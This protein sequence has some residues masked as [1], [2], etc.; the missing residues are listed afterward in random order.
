V[1]RLPLALLLV[2]S[3]VLTSAQ[4]PPPKPVGAVSGTRSS[5]PA[6]PV[7]EV[8][9]AKPEAPKPPA[10]LTEV[11]RL[12][13]QNLLQSIEL[14]QLKA[15]TAATE[16]TKA[17]ESLTKFLQAVTPTGWRLNDRLEFVPVDPP[18]K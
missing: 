15:Q 11:Q 9:K 18:K 2:V 12:Q 7:V 4:T 16:G 17:R 5:A 3:G 8:P 10:P 14:W 1:T 6:G 13:V